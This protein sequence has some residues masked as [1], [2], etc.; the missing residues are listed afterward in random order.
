M[1]YI[2]GSDTKGN[3]KEAARSDVNILMVI[4]VKEHKILLVHIPR[5]YYV[6]INDH[7]GKDRLMNS[8]IYGINTSVK[9]IEQLFDI[10]INHYLKA[11]FPAIVSS[12]DII[13]GLDIYSD[14]DFT[15]WT[16]QNCKFKTGVQHIDGKCA[17][18]FARERKTYSSDD[19]HRGENQEQIISKMIE[20]LTD[21]R[22]LIKYNDIL[23]VI[24]DSIE[25]SMSYEEITNFVKEELSTLS[26][27]KIESYNVNGTN[28]NRSRI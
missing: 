22:Y 18:A 23:N 24:A 15:A 11:S 12:I 9:T 17:L 19:S 13:G 28:Q 6:N 5:D 14:K 27:F 25:T 16:D 20:K 1:L 3:I 7:E 2:S 8:G 21:P 26:K 10:K 4:N